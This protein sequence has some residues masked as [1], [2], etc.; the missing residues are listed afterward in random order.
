MRSVLR[1]LGLLTCL[2]PLPA[3]AGWQAVERVEAYAISGK[4]GIEL[5]RSIGDNGPKVGVGRTIAYTDFKL[6]WSRDYRPQPDGSCVLVSARPSLTITYRLPRPK[7]ELPAVTRRLWERFIEG[8]TAHEKVHGEIITD[9]VKKIEAISVGLTV[10][11]DPECRKIRAELTSYLGE[12]SQEQRR[13]SREFD[14]AEMSKGG[15]VHQ[16][17]LA[18]VNG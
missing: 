1:I 12:L 15:N 5:Y 4:T 6:L 17:I 9:M 18:L 7:G 13:R 10:A 2:A 8:V 14:K 3:H 11:D 16:L